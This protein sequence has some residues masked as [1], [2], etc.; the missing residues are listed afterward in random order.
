MTVGQMDETT[1]TGSSEK[2]TKL[3]R[4]AVEAREGEGLG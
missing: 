4:E 3:A 1:R 2:K